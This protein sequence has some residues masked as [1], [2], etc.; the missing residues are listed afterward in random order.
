MNILAQNLNNIQQDREK[1]E[2]LVLLIL[3]YN[4]LSP[5]ERQLATE[6]ELH[7]MHYH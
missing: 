4:F 7:S 6:S 3:V 2:C 5:N 1:N